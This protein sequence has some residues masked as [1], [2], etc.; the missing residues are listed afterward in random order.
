M[1][2]KI[3]LKIK[4]LEQQ[5]LAKLNKVAEIQNEVNDIDAKIKKLNNFKKS[6]EKLENNSTEYLN[7]I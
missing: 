5:K 3:T 2:K 6:Y 1:I 7:N 4:R